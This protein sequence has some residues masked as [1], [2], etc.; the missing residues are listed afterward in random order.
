MDHP[1]VRAWLDDA[2]FRPGQLRTLDEELLRAP[3]AET[4]EAGGDPGIAEL[5][6]HL[7]GCAEC[8]GELAA[9]RSTAVALD[10]ALGPPAGARQRIL[11]N[12]VAVGR[13]RRAPPR[14]AWWAFERP[15]LSTATALAVIAAIAFGLGAVLALMLS[16]NTTQPSRLAAVVTQMNERL[17]EPGV[18]QAIL[19]D[20]DGSGA[21][22]VVLS[23]AAQRLAVMST[24]LELR[25][26]GN[27]QCYL[28]RDGQRTL[29]GP[30]HFEEQVAFWAGPI[31]APPD[32]G[33]AG[34][35]F[36]VL[37]GE[38]DAEP[39]LQTEF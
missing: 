15:T 10:L 14:R 31:T 17:A 6:L 24:A 7:A 36:L 19:R 11:G 37:Y 2:F 9:L 25:A 13:E 20:R 22:L 18:K 21:G 38:A 26:D 23:P 35:R 32:A 33:R 4:G 27:Y 5:R 3:D 34:D 39:E 8:S 29:I 16:S 12:V 28:E 1:E 30:M